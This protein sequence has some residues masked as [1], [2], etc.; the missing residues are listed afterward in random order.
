MSSY[1]LFGTDLG[2]MEVVRTDLEQRLG[3]RF[4]A[5]E[6]L[7]V[8]DYY[9]AE[10]SGEGRVKIR[11]NLDPLDH[12]PYELQFPDHDILIYMDEVPNAAEA[13]AA[14]IDGGFLLLRHEEL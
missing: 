8:G 3:C 7:Y 9:L 11:R 2:D 10:M 6:S 13:R 12:E 14:L 5:R 1:D 4:V